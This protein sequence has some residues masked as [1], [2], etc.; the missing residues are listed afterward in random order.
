[1]LP[2]SP[3][4]VYQV[5]PLSTKQVASPPIE[6]GLKA[7]A[8]IMWDGVGREEELVRMCWCWR[9]WVVQCVILKLGYSADV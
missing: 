7:F 5:L 4:Q 3:R 8:R 6:E 2:S 9:E 1:M